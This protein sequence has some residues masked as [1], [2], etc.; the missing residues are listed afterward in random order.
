[1]SVAQWEELE[2]REPG[3]D[4]AR[5]MAQLMVRGNATYREWAPRF[6]QPPA[7][8]RTHAQ[9]NLRLR[10]TDRWTRLATCADGHV[11]ALVSW[12]P[13]REHGDEGIDLP[14]AA[15][16]SHLY[17]EP[18]RWG[19]GIASGLL[20]LAEAAMRDGGSDRALLWTPAAA[21]ARGFYERCGWTADGRERWSTELHLP[22]VGYE[23]RL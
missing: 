7:F 4:D 18:S 13:A 2:V 17:V 19:N 6:W 16:V 8:Q 12:R 3:R 15:Y 22:M 9:W 23:K 20:E 1:V 21:P 11:V 5:A 14:G 10:E